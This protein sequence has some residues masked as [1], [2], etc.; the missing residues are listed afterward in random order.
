MTRKLTEEQRA[1][2]PELKAKGYT[3]T[4][5]ARVFGVS[6]SCI[7]YWSNPEKYREQWKAAN[8]R[9]ADSNP[10]RVKERSR[11]HSQEHVSRL[12]T[13]KYVTHST[14]KRP[15]PAGCEICGR[16][17]HLRHRHWDDNKPYVGI[18]LCEV[19]HRQVEHIDFP[20]QQDF[21]GKYLVLK[22]AI[23]NKEVRND[24]GSR[25]P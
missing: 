17:A 2:V 5:I 19:C 10:E 21:V 15:K 16:A 13:G 12:R 11:L 22:E 25:Q 24:P 4:Q 8:K 18:W 1:R 14:S 3:M 23:E 20:P 6:K 7:T 9:F